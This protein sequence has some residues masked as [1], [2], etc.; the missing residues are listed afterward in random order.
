MNIFSVI[1][2]AVV[3]TADQQRAKHI[4]NE[5]RRNVTAY[6]T[7]GMAVR[8][9]LNYDKTETDSVKT[10]VLRRVR[11]EREFATGIANVDRAAKRLIKNI[12]KAI[13]AHVTS[14]EMIRQIDAKEHRIKALDHEYKAIQ[15]EQS[16]HSLHDYQVRDCAEKLEGH[17]VSLT[18]AQNQL[19]KA[20]RQEE[21]ARAGVKEGKV[22]FNYIE[23]T[24]SGD[25][26][27]KFWAHTHHPK[28]IAKH[29]QLTAMG[30]DATIKAPKLVKPPVIKAA[31]PPE[32]VSGLLNNLEGVEVKVKAT[33]K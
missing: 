19:D 22:F 21:V 9:F 8:E 25:R 30:I 18:F 33:D 3:G 4:V 16:G 26:W 6:Q 28:L 11:K 23:K 1:K 2:Q 5:I 27:L 29:G 32:V 10:E 17:V 13:Y 14:L 15:L 12:D 20:Y 31:T 7:F 24:E